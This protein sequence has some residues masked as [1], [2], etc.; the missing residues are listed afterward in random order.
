M[1][2]QLTT[3][4]E[5]VSQMYHIGETRF[6]MAERAHTHLSAVITTADVNADER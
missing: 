4:R 2:E 1:A 6:K 5:I 3:R